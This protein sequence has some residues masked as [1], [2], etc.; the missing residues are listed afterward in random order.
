VENISSII[1][2]SKLDQNTSYDFLNGQTPAQVMLNLKQQKIA[3]VQIIQ[4][5]DA[6]EFQ[7]S[8]DEMVNY[9]ERVKIYGETE[10]MK[11]AIQLHP[12]A[13]P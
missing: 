3:E 2:L 5:F 12:P 1:V 8:P 4:S 11:W 10:A 7:M 9:S 13:N 6:V